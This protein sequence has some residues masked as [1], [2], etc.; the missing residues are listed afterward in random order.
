M[1]KSPSPFHAGELEAQSRVGIT[2]LAKRVGS[3]IRD[4]LPE[5]HRSFHISLPFLIASSADQSG[6]IWVTIIEGEEGGI[7]SP[8]ERH[9][10]I[11][12]RLRV[13]DPLVS[14]FDNGSEVGVLGIDFETRRR[15]RFNGYLTPM[16]KGYSIEIKQSFGNCPK[17]INQ[18]KWLKFPG[19]TCS[20]AL[21]TNVLTSSQIVMINHSDTLFI[22]SGQLNKLEDSTSGFDASHRGGH[23]GFVRVINN[24]QL[25]IPD[26]SGNN[27]FNTIGNLIE[28]PKIGLLFVDF[29][30][31]KL[32]HISGQATINWNTSDTINSNVKNST[33]EETNNKNT[34]VVLRSILVNI[35]RVIERSNAISLR[36]RK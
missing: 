33:N 5:Q 8:D 36:W 31:G 13:D 18:K 15:N 6:N 10:Q 12:A 11:S 30:T 25:Q 2:N 22:G 28:N 35:D 14:S 26:Y 24:A 21:K 34:P 7:A 17:Y 29:E 20:H 1:L 32:L 19:S 27:F 23:A 4:F 16:D 9:I 3:F